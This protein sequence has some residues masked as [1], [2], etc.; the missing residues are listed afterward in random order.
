MEIFR[1]GDEGAGVRDI[2]D[3]LVAL[4][5]PVDPAERSGSFGVSTEAAVRAFQKARH[6]R[7]D[8]LVGTDTWSQLVEAG[9]VLGDR[10]LYAHA[11]F[12]RG[13]DV[14]ALQ[15]KLNALGFDAGKEDGLFG[16]RTDRAIRDFQRN[17]GDESDGIAGP[18]T[19]ATLQRM[20]PQE[21]A[22]S[23]ALV[24]EREQIR[25]ARGAIDGRVV[26]LDV[27]P[28]SPRPDLAIQITRTLAEEL[29]RAGAKVV[30]LPDRD[31]PSAASER[32]RAANELEA[33][34]CLSVE[35]GAG[36]PEAGGPTCSYFGSRTTHSPT[37]MLLA[38]LILEELEQ[39]LDR[40]GR[41]QRLTQSILRETR[42]PAVMVEPI[43]ETSAKDAVL[44]ADP[45]F[46][47]R[48]GRSIATGVRR[49]FS[50]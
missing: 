29:G 41:L 14:R 36:L 5:L 42:M 38:T 28:G 20:R 15:R 17:V 43:I 21:D 25:G 1:P 13:D 47:P 26:A 24:R 48:V 37:G 2:Q 44:L 16:P 9:Y 46:A 34:I 7:V 32:A 50:G 35:L 8:G 27:E 31:L 23:R 6:L 45:G 12:F 33:A 30:V 19:I 4:G 10:T 3:R 40:R 49:F 22:P 39:E 11:P 18:H